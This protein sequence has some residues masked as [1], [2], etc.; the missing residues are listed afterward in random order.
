M[1]NGF[2]YSECHQEKISLLL[3]RWVKLGLI[4]MDDVIY[5]AVN[6]AVT[7][8]VA[9]SDLLTLQPALDAGL[10]DTSNMIVREMWRVKP[11]PSK[12]QASSCAVMGELNCST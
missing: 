7:P 11:N 5:P 9:N 12:I 10:F 1:H 4:G 3:A 8:L 6:D 2:D